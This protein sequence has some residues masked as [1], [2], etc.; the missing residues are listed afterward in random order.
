[1]PN[2][3]A[4]NQSRSTPERGGGAAHGLAGHALY[5]DV[6]GTVL[7]LAPR[8]DAVDVPPWIVPALQRIAGRLGGAVAF[9]SGRTILDI[10]ALFAPLRLPTVG[11]H[12]GEIRLADG[13]LWIDRAPHAALR[14]AAPL[15][16][17]SIARWPGVALEDKRGALALHYRA[18]PE[19]GRDVLEV[20]ELVARGMGPEFAVLLGKCVV[21]IRPRHLTKG[22]AVSRLMQKPPFSGRTPIFAGDDT[23]D[24]D[25]FDVVNR[26]GG[27]SMRVGASAPTAARYALADP[28]QLRAWLLQIADG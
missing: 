6:D 18:A 13:S 8:P 20:A 14:A 25:A 28:D 10:D 9:V 15:L 23:T 1:M 26:A 24:E 17:Q 12:G 3:D 11:V 22:A 5:L 27:I 19:R 21:E 2:S 16:R 7:D 4:S